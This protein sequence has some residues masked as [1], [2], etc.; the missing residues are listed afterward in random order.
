MSTRD[1]NKYGSFED[2]FLANIDAESARNLREHG[3][4]CGIGGL[5]YY[6][7][8][9]ALFQAFEDEIERLATDNYD[10]DIWQIAKASD[11]RGI[12]QI[13]NALVWIAAERLAYQLKSQLDAQQ[14]E[15]DED[16][17]VAAGDADE[18]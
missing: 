15:S 18:T 2:W 6:S 12:T 7:E 10:T 4:S 17:A 13:I 14:D 8:T 3:A 1:V 5:C 16:Q 9:S 11:A